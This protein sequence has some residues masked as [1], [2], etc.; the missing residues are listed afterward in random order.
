MNDPHQRQYVASIGGDPEPQHVEY[1]RHIN[2][3]LAGR[4]EGMID[5]TYTCAGATS[6]RRGRPRSYDFV[7]EA[8]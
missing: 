8:P 1:I 6:A 4:P 2:E 7:A 3:A 5:V